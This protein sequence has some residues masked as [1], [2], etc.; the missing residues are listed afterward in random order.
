[1]TSTLQHVA[2]TLQNL[3]HVMGYLHTNQLQGKLDFLSIYFY[4]MS[5]FVRTIVGVFA[6]KTND[7]LGLAM[8]IH[9]DL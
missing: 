9:V 5:L 8:N 3:T 6:R 2:M 1:L 4:E 7:W